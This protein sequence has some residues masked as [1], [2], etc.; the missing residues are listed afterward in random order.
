MC[1]IHKILGVTFKR[2]RNPNWKGPSLS[3]FVSSIEGMIYEAVQKYVTRY[4]LSYC[5]GSKNEKKKT[6]FPHSHKVYSFKMHF[7]LSRTVAFQAGILSREVRMDE[8]SAN[9]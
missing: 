1:Y 4:S 8:K 2:L 9:I 5:Y 3:S 6:Y 7:Y